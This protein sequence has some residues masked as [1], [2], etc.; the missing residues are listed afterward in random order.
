MQEY[1][2]IKGQ[3][4]YDS[5]TQTFDLTNGAFEKS[6]AIL[7]ELN[8]VPGLVAD[9]MRNSEVVN[10]GG[11]DDYAKKFGANVDGVSDGKILIIN[12]STWD[13]EWLNPSLQG[14]DWDYYPVP[15]EVKGEG[16]P[17]VHADYGMMLSTAKDPE[18][19]F[20][21]L[22]Y[23]T[24]GKDGILKRMELQNAN[25]D[26]LYENNRFTIPVSTHPEVAEA[27]KAS[28]NVPDGIAYMYDN[29]DK[30]IKGD[31]SKVLPDYWAVINDSIYWAKV[32]ISEGEDAASVA[33][34]TQ[35]KL[36]ETFGE[37]W[38]TFSEKMQQVQKDFEA[39]KTQ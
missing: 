24:Y 36:N 39:M 35:E 14:V 33:K 32:R 1:Q 7:D 37:S 6:V 10:A 9:A 5:A 12:A 15:S 11:M 30:A 13:D 28:E 16:R 27:F 25:A 4:G 38:K 20:Q 34:E 8:K 3:W 18:A 19:A 21:L 23:I 2:G 31:Y 26:N 29:L 22:K 17:I